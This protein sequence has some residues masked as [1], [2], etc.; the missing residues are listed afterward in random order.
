MVLLS[1][2]RENS[3]PLKPSTLLVSTTII[4]VRNICLHSMEATA[5][6]MEKT[7]YT[8]ICCFAK[9]GLPGDL[10]AQTL[11]AAGCLASTAVLLIWAAFSRRFFFFSSISS[12]CFLNHN[13]PSCLH[14]KHCPLVSCSSCGDIKWK[15][16]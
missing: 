5:I 13:L 10:A 2:I 6:I 14:R 12:S 16:S 15:C 8:I 3:I 1:F 11:N 9:S 7:F 4:I